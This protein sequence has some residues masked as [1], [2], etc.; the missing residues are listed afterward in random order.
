MARRSGSCPVGPSKSCKRRRQ[1]AYVVAVVNRD[2]YDA[3]AA[4]DRDD[5]IDL[6]LPDWGDRVDL[7]EVC[8]PDAA[9]ARLRSV[10]ERKGCRV[11]SF[12]YGATMQGTRKR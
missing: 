4:V 2:P 5:A 7:Y 10:Y 3:H 1:H 8:A 12:T 6:A 9:T 11:R